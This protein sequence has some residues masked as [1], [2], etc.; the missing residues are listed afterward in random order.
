MMQSNMLKINQ[1]NQT[2]NLITQL[3]SPQKSIY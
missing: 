3:Q 1:N 2:I